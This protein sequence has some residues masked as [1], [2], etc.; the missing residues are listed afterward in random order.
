MDPQLFPGKMYQCCN[1]W[2][3]L[4][5]ANIH[6]FGCFPWRYM[7]V[8]ICLFDYNFLISLSVSEAKWLP[9]H[10]AILLAPLACSL[11]RWMLSRLPVC[12][13]S[14][15]F[16]SSHI[17]SYGFLVRGLA[18]FQPLFSYSYSMTLLSW[19]LCALCQS[20]VNRTRETDDSDGHSWSREWGAGAQREHLP[21]GSLAVSVED[22]ITLQ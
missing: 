12:V 17:P 1:R 4:L 20:S 8:W 14:Y 11:S 18:F 2:A 19:S 22:E 7:E 6:F 9:E 15:I 16:I 5:F 21:L 10:L 13:T 3:K